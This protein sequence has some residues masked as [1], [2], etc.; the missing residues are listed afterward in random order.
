MHKNYHVYAEKERLLEAMVGRVISRWAS[1]ETQMLDLAMW[2][3]QM[4]RRDTAKLTSAFKNFSLSLEFTQ[5]VCSPRLRDRTFLNSLVDLTRELSGDRNFIAHTQISSHGI[6][7]PADG[8]WAN[9]I[10]LVGPAAK[11]HFAETPQKREPMD[12]KEVAE[13]AADIQHLVE[14]L[15]EFCRALQGGE[16]WP[17][18]FYKPVEPRRPRLA[19]R[20]AVS[21]K[22]QRRS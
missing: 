5:S 6:G 4:S 13:V 9:T 17:E 3:L 16:P 18:K 15:L 21:G 2:G 8:D 10:P 7:H 19:E 11:N 22:L 14:L 12:V 20:R 1:L